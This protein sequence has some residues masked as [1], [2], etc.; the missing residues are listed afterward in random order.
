MRKFLWFL[1]LLWPAL[2]VAQ[3]ALQTPGPGPIPGTAN[4]VLG[5]INAFPGQLFC[6]GDSYIFGTGAPAPSAQDACALISKGMPAG[7]PFVN[8]AISGLASDKIAFQTFTYFSPFPQIPTVSIINGGGN[9]GPCGTSAACLTNYQEEMLASEAWL[10]IPYS[11]RIMG[12]VATGANWVTDTSFPS[13]TP[14]FGAT[15]WIA[16]PGVPVSTTTSG[17][18]KT[19][20]VPSSASPVVGV[21]FQVTNAQAGTFT[22]S[23]D[24][25]LQTD[26]CSGTTTFTSAP[27]GGLSIS[28]TTSPFR[29]EFSVT[30]GTTHTVIVTTT[31]TSKVDVLCVDW[32]P[33]ASTVNLN[34]AFVVN[35]PIIFSNAATYNV[36]SAANVAKLQADGLPVYLV[37]LVN[38]TPGVNGTTDIATSATSTCDASLQASHPNSQCGYVHFAQTIYN[39]ELASGYIFSGSPNP[40]NTISPAYVP[41]IVSSIDLSFQQAAISNAAL[42]TA[43]FSGRYRITYY[44]S[45]STAATVSSVLGGSTG[46]SVTYLDGVD[47]VTRTVTLPEINQ[48]GTPL[49]VASGNTTNTTAAIIQGSFMLDANN[50]DAVTYSLG[51]T[52]S[53]S[54]VMQYQLHIRVEQMF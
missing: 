36:A 29:Q 54:T 43:P 28:Q 6:V 35:T 22:V 45:L 32:V 12:S 40:Q 51:Y 31:N 11:F 4:S 48:S 34:T 21:T 41:Q 44:V 42:F 52:S 7:T 24:G 16:S 10:T 9:D 25:T 37:D 3:P 1:M 38:G 23:V 53:G 46:L 17:A 47:F 39:E 14:G 15:A 33:P 5:K 26:Q 19:F 18:T 13:V 2:V 30:P 20:S 50:G 27:C 49:V 8:A